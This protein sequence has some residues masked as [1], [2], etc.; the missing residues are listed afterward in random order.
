MGNLA[1]TLW[2][3]GERTTALELME[4]A[5]VGREKILGTDHPDAR[6]SANDLARSREAFDPSTDGKR[7]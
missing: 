4:A 5:A 7:P 2:Q 1:V 6:S 3:M